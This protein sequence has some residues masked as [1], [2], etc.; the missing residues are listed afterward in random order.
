MKHRTIFQRRKIIGSGL[1]LGVCL[2]FIGLWLSGCRPQTD[3]MRNKVF[4]DRSAEESCLQFRKEASF[5]ESGSE[6]HRS[7]SETEGE[8]ADKKGTEK[9]SIPVE[10]SSAK[11]SADEMSASKDESPSGNLPS[12]QEDSSQDNSLTES[13]S[14][15]EDTSAIQENTS[16]TSEEG[17]EKGPIHGEGAKEES[18]RE[19][20]IPSE[21]PSK[22]DASVDEPGNSSEPSV[23]VHTLG[24]EVDP[25]GN[26]TLLRQTCQECGAWVQKIAVVEEIPYETVFWTDP[27]GGEC[28]RIF[29]DPS[30]RE[31]F[32]NSLFSQGISSSF[33]TGQIEYRIV[34]WTISYSDNY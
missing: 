22:E 20:T 12:Y 28:S 17:N 9:G 4:V 11:E 19:E 32:R 33:L 34:D 27:E 7:D 14:I 16:S 2:V 13:S 24:A 3:D 26:G 5:S 25:F 10:E 21:E 1:G 30:E 8:K 15:Q 31:A 18:S 6:K 23:H 29:Y